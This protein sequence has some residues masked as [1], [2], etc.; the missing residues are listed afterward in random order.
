LKAQ[1]Y[2]AR[3]FENRVHRP[4][5]ATISIAGERYIL[6]R[7]A[8]MSVEFVELVMSL[9]RDRGPEEARSV[10]NN[11]LFDLAHA[12]GKAD[13]RSFHEKMG[14]VDPIERLSAGPI[15]FAFSGWAFVHI[16]PESRPSPDDDYFLLFDHPFS[17]E[18]HAWSPRGS[19]A[20][21]RSA[22]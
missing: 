14:V 22:S 8:S 18:S 12:I 7:A 3:Y 16:L 5:E 11:L 10:A 20:R 13:A 17:F 9:Y 4:D 1:A 2:V 15:H 19:R 6:L 21:P